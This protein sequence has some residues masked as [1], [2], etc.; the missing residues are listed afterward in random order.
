M[1]HA[2]AGILPWHKYL[3]VQYFEPSPYYVGF[4]YVTFVSFHFID[5]LK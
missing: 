4:L 2:L 1:Y 5:L 3:H